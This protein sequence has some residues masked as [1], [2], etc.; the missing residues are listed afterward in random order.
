MSNR[1]IHIQ[2]FPGKIQSMMEVLWVT[3]SNKIILM[4]A[5][6]VLGDMPYALCL[7]HAVENTGGYVEGMWY[8]VHSCQVWSLAD[9]DRVRPRPLF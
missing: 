5:K 8:I 9:R 7:M 1:I 3:I 4:I 2:L 6:A